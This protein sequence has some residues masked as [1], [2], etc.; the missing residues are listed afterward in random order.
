MGYVFIESKLNSLLGQLVPYRHCKQRGNI[1]PTVLIYK[2]RAGKL[3]LPEPS[4]YTEQKMSALEILNLPVPQQLT[5]NKRIF[6]HKVLNNNSPNYLA[7]PFIS[8]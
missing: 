8:H 1:T 6:M 2:R 3:I 4:Q 5:Y 7:Q